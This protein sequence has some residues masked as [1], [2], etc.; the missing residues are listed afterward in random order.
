MV[1]GIIPALLISAIALKTSSHMGE[2]IGKSYLTMA[3]HVADTVD[4]S[5]FE[6]Y[7]DVQA[8]AAN[9]VLQD[10][11]SWYKTG[12]ELN[13][14]AALT[15]RL[16]SL[17]GIYSLCMMV[18]LEGN[19][20]AVNDEDAK[21]NAIDTAPIYRRSYKNADWFRDT[22][23]GHTIRGEEL[24]G[25]YI[26]APYA[27]EEVRRVLGGEGYSI[28]FSTLVKDASNKPIGI[29][30]N[31][32]SLGFIEEVFAKT[33]E[34]FRREKIP[35]ADVT[36]I[37]SK[38]RLLVDYDPSLS[39]RE[40]PNHDRNVLL[41]YNLAEK[42]SEVAKLLVAGKSGYGIF[43]HTRKNIDQMV[44]YSVTKGH[45]GF[46]GLKWGVMVRVPKSAALGPARTQEFEIVFAALLS[47]AALVYTGLKISRKISDPLQTGI[48]SL[49]QITRSLQYTGS[50]IELSSQ[51]VATGAS[52][53]AASVEE[54]SASLEE[55][56]AMTKRTA[57]N[58]SDCRTLSRR[59]KESATAGLSS[60]DQMGQTLNSIRV[61]IREMK[62]AVIEMQ[63]SSRD[64]SK[65]IRT[66]DEIAFQT[67]LLALNAAVEAARAGE[68]GMGFAVVADEVRALAQRSALAAKETSEKIEASISRSENGTQVSLKVADSLNEVETSAKNIEEVFKGIVS[69]VGSLDEVIAGMS[70]ATMEQSAGISE[71]T[72]A[73]SEMDKV[74]QANAASAEENASTCEA[75][76]TQVENIHEVVADLHFLLSGHES[77]Q[78]L[79]EESLTASQNSPKARRTVRAIAQQSEPRSLPALQKPSRPS[80]RKRLRYQ[81]R[82]TESSDDAPSQ[83]IP[84]PDDDAE[85]QRLENSFRNF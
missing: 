74:I 69:Q 39:G 42:G 48:E 79:D 8:F 13:K 58:S 38:G 33:Y 80:H 57:E 34:H 55:I 17:Y 5:L 83:A 77:S 50:E 63:E 72:T 28:G 4:R 61:S 10:K 68:A 11:S 7:G 9:E 1:T 6:R 49:D 73:V 22:L 27:D 54:T 29:L 15:N 51:R 24:D 81:P 59:T 16:V 85:Q 12:S 62:E 44:G 46:P 56:S 21:G 37:D 40:G 31:V 60:L 26:Q 71:I 52:E 82:L 45:Q 84:M 53:Q 23:A 65:I 35:T 41:K 14:I 64:V 67:N 19:V 25:T 20:V 36:L 66:I 76:N 30:R 43:R 75:L 47:I 2:D 18:D 70:N 3:E 78:N 32:A